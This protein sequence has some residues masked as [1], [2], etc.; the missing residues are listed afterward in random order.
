MLRVVT[1]EN[2]VRS[3]FDPAKDKDVYE[4]EMIVAERG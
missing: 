2:H 3:A 1:E 4:A